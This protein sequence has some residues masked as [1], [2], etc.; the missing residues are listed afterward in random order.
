VFPVTVARRY[1]HE[2]ENGLIDKAHLKSAVCPHRGRCSVRNFIFLQRVLSVIHFPYFPLD[3]GEIRQSNKCQEFK[4]ERGSTRLWNNSHWHSAGIKHVAS[5]LKRLYELHIKVYNPRPARLYYAACGHICK[6]IKYNKYT[7]K[8]PHKF[9][10]VDILLII[11]P[12]VAQKRAHSLCCH[13]PKRGWTPYSILNL[14]LLF[15]WMFGLLPDHGF[16]F[17]SSSQS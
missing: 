11:F 7:T 5:V 10:Q 6:Y 14:L 17:S 16:L 12:G 9:M 15:L 13:M 8:I 4:Q 1:S 2:R 3:V